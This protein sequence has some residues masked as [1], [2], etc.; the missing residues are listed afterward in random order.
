MPSYDYLHEAAVFFRNYQ[1]LRSSRKSEHFMKPKGSLPCS[2]EPATGLYPEP[3]ESSPP[4]K[5]EACG[6]FHNL[7]GFYSAGLLAPKLETDH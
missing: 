3:D 4:Y 2:Q 1:L 7:L 5:S 6:T